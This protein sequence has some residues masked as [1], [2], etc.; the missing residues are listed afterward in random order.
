[1]ADFLTRD[2]SSG[3]LDQENLNKIILEEGTINPVVNQA[4][5]FAGLTKISPAIYLVE[6]RD[7][8]GRLVTVL[9]RPQQKQF[10]LYRNKPGSCQF[11]LDLYDPQATP[12][13]LANSINSVVF[14]RNST[15][16]FAGQITYHE[17]KVTDSDS[18]TVDVV[19]TGYFDQLDYRMVT[20][21]YPG[22]DAI[23][24]KLYFAPQDAGQVA[25]TLIN[26]AQFPVPNADD[27]T[28]STVTIDGVKT[29]QQSF[30]ASG[31]ALLKML[32]FVVQ[33]GSF[34]SGTVKSATTTTLTDTSASWS[35]NA[36]VGG[37]VSITTGTDSGDSQIIVS[38]T[39]TAITLYGN[40]LVYTGT[41][42]STG[43][44][45]LTDSGASFPTSG[46]GLKGGTLAITGG[47]DS[48]DNR[49]IFSNTSTTITI[50]GAWQTT[51]DTTSTYTATTSICNGLA[52]S[53]TTSTITDSNQ[54][55]L[56]N[57]LVGKA[58]SITSGT[59][60]SDAA[61]IVS[62]TAT[63]ITIQ[64]TWLLTPDTTSTYQITPQLTGT[65]SLTPDNTSS[66]SIIPATPLT[67]GNLTVSLINDSGGTPTGSVVANSTKTIAM[68]TIPNT[69]GWFEIDYAAS[70]GVSL[71]GGQTYWLS[72]SLDTVQTAGNGLLVQ[73]LNTNYYQNGKAT[74]LT[75]PTLFT[76]DQDIQFFVLLT[77]NS[78]QM[79]KNTYMGIQQGTIQPSFRIAPIFDRYKHIKAAIEDLSTVWNGIDFSITV[80]I[81]PAT[82]YMTKYFNVYYPGIGQQNTALNFSYPG[83]IKK[84]NKPKDGTKLINEVYMRGQGSGTA[85][86]LAVARDNSSLA[87]YGV[88][89]SDQSQP[90]ISDQTTLTSFAIEYIRVNSTP[91]DLPGMILDGNMPPSIGT[92]GIGDFIAIS[93]NDPRAPILSF[94]QSYRCEALSTTID[95]DSVEEIEI[96]L[97]N[98]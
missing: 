66:Y 42:T 55:W 77:D 31:T 52:T 98:I 67:T 3:Y 97:S 80:Q 40:N 49:I 74:S 51:P 37:T 25:W 78:Y 58:I 11:V 72:L 17:P 96:Q 86:L 95:D 27:S 88:R 84:M 36:F 47:T 14:R 69:L 24:N 34:F 15:P 48:G 26:Y 23:H 45:T 21:D 32:K 13:N 83:N 12:L 70:P 50:V 1:M 82:N 63:T 18:K 87:S 30:Q 10:S 2:G 85:Q 71:T 60:V 16:V 28:A 54:S 61:S 90:D 65:W 81:D 6:L 19:A 68:N 22:F 94:N 4:T 62:N 8:Y 44:T 39:A 75:N 93:V 7:P 33:N 43:T 59:D 38:N 41:A 5:S 91:S 56:T 20:N 89:Q 76:S 64:G 9:A 92:Y 35:T 73:V 79:T 57:A 46:N 53:A 29:V